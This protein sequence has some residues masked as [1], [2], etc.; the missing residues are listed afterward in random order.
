MSCGVGKTL[1]YSDRETS[2]MLVARGKKE[3]INIVALGIIP[4]PPRSSFSSSVKKE[5][6]SVALIKV[7]KVH[8]ESDGKLIWRRRQINDLRQDLITLFLSLFAEKTR[9][10]GEKNLFL[11]RIIINCSLQVS[12]PGKTAIPRIKNTLSALNLL[13]FSFS[14]STYWSKRFVLRRSLV[15][16]KSCECLFQFSSSIPT[17]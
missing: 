3:N 10:D 15:F 4:H 9:C 17:P 5:R 16:R 13:L 7:P 2:D 6:K 1:S 14:S 8:P 12:C 11:R